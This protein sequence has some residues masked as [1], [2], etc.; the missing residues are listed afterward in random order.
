MK[1]G[2]CPKCGAQT[3]YRNQHKGPVSGVGSILVRGGAFDR[4][5]PLAYYVCTT[6]GH[7]EMYLEDAESLSYIT[8]HWDRV[9]G[10]GGGSDTRRLPTLPP[11]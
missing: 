1:D 10:A 4:P 8:D 3:V 11:L 6:C 7:Y 2:Q 5:E 9:E